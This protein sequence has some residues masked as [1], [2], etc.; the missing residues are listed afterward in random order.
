MEKK[1]ETLNKKCTECLETRPMFE[2]PLVKPNTDRRR[3]YCYICQR[4]KKN[5]YYQK[6][7]EMKTEYQRNYRIDNLE[8]TRKYHNEYM[9]ER[10]KDNPDYAKY[11]SNNSIKSY[12]KYHEKN[13][14]NHRMRGRERLKTKKQY[15]NMLRKISNSKRKREVYEINRFRQCKKINATIGRF[16]KD[17]LEIYRKCKEMSTDTLKYQVDHIIPLNNDKIC[18]LHVP[19]NL[20]IL[21]AYHNGSK[22][23]SFDGTYENESWKANL[24]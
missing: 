14:S 10:K 8:K 18:G 21:T 4:R 9:K 22:W 13:K 6:N 23:N 1:I 3:G 16:K 24:P 17:L 15:V 2:Y 19:W 5:E 12:Y 11:L 7:K 20:Q